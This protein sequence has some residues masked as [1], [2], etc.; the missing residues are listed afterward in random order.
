LTY[1]RSVCRQNNKIANVTFENVKIKSDSVNALAK[2]CT[3]TRIN[4]YLQIAVKENAYKELERVLKER[5]IRRSF[6]GH[7][8]IP[9][10]GLL[11]TSASS[12]KLELPNLRRITRLTTI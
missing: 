10:L 6:R 2:A 9:V 3:F 4:E 1:R 8:Y 7:G 12:G 11:M 5:D